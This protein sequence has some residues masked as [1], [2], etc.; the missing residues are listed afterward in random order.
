M[1]SIR[2]LR[3]EARHRVYHY[4]RAK[5]KSIS[6]GIVNDLEQDKAPE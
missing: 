1:A 5:S 6:S 4:L 2:E 3:K